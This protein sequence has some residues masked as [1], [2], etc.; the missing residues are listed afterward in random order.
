M[1]TRL[2]RFKI[3]VTGGLVL[4]VAHSFLCIVLYKVSL[5][6][7]ELGVLWEHMRLID[8]P[9]SLLLDEFTDGYWKQFPGVTYHKPYLI[10]HLVFGGLQFFAWGWLLAVVG[11]ECTDAF[12]KDSSP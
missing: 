3:E 4:W 5:R 7:I 1:W 12:G 9:V 2:Q 8:F 11:K 6:N 10:F